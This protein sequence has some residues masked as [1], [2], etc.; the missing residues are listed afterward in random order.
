MNQRI[1]ARSNF[2]VYITLAP[3]TMW[4]C[5]VSSSIFELF[6]T[7]NIDLPLTS[8]NNQQPCRIV[9]TSHLLQHHQSGS[10]RDCSIYSMH[11]TPLLLPPLHVDPFNHLPPSQAIIS[12][13]HQ[14]SAANHHTA[15][16][17]LIV[18]L[19]HHRLP[20]MTYPPSHHK[21]EVS[22]SPSSSSPIYPA[23]QHR[24]WL[25]VTHFAGERVPD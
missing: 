11:S 22:K 20:F 19:Q 23:V 24:V 3:L 21:T 7:S 9:P 12:D 17:T 8:V 1:R 6:L 18:H 15:F 2:A 13:H 14:P 4:R 25:A 10:S 16:S 5:K